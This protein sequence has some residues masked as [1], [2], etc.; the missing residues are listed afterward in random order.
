MFIYL[1]ID[2]YCT[3]GSK[4]KIADTLI[5][6]ISVFIKSCEKG[7]I[8]KEHIVMDTHLTFGFKWAVHLSTL[9]VKLFNSSTKLF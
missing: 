9:A 1:I 8:T 2:G 5:S 3:H 4:L 6:L 7:L